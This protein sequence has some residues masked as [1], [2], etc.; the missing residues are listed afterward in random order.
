M[1]AQVQIYLPEEVLR[2]AEALARRTG[3]SVEDVLAES[4]E[5]SLNPLGVSESECQGISNWPDEK[6]L[7]A[8]QLEL[9]EETDRR[10]SELLE[11]RRE[12]ELDESERTEQ[13]ALMQRYQDG[14]LRKAQALREAVLR[15]L[16]GPLKS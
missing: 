13:A 5:L 6:V 8:S 11:K 16:L 3:R 10:L 12:G 7:A 15:G 14:L 9:E 4:I 2:R 1:D